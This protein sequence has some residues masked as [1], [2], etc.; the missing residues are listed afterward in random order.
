ILSLLICN[1]GIVI[2]KLKKKKKI[3]MDNFMD[4]YVTSN[5]IAEV[6]NFIIALIVLHVGWL[7]AKAIASAVEKGL[8]KTEFD[9]KV[10]NKFRTSD[11]PVYFYQIIANLVYYILSLI[12][13]VLFFIL[14]N[15]DMIANPLSDLVFTFFSCIP[16]LLNAAVILIL[17]WVVATA[18][19]WFIVQGTKKMNFQHLF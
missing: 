7:I 5:F 6:Q 2:H 15:L 19:Q 9:E 16:A 3:Y 14:F 10:F 4:Q 8:G 12:V 18:M 17:A 11:K 1:G 13:F